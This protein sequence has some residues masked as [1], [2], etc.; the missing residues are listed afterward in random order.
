MR[1][2]ISSPNMKSE[3]SEAQAG[4][5]GKPNAEERCGHKAGNPHTRP[6]HWVCYFECEGKGSGGWTGVRGGDTTK[7]DGVGSTW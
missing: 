1:G 7:K 2:A 6:E 4:V 3:F 5:K